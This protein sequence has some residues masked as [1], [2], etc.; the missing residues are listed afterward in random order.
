[1]S[2]ATYLL[3]IYVCLDT[4]LKKWKE[5]FEALIIHFTKVFTNQNQKKLILL[6]IFC[7]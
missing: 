2:K 3:H 6:C 7:V 5:K 1:M 4:L